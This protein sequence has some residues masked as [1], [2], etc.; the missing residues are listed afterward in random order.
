[1]MDLANRYRDLWVAGVLGGMQT[2]AFSDKTI[3]KPSGRP[4]L[5]WV[6]FKECDVKLAMA[7]HQIFQKALN[8]IDSV[9]ELKSICSNQ[10][11]SSSNM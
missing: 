11:Q 8:N 1:M 10:R 2:S 7:L 6:T 9:K 3:S 4:D 5:S